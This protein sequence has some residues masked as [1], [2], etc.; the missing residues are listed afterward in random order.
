M[1]SVENAQLRQQLSRV[2][3][4]KSDLQRQNLQLT[5]KNDQQKR[6]LDQARGLLRDTA[7]A[8]ARSAQD[9]L[10]FLADNNA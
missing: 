1:A 6:E 3:S 2:Q 9:L 4:E 10:D 5:A 7:N 8:S